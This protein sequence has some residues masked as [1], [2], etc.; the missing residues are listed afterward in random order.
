MRRVIGS[1]AAIGSVVLL[2]WLMAERPVYSHKPITTP[3]IFKKEIAQIFQRKCFQCHSENNLAMPL[4]TYELARPWARAIREEILARHMPPWGAVHGFGEFANDLGLTQREMDIILSWADGGAPSGVVKAEENVPPVYVPAEPQWERGAPDEVVAV[5]AP[6]TVAPGSGDQIH[7]FELRTTLTTPRTIKALAFKPGDRRVVRYASVGDSAS[8]R[9][10]WSWT[11]WQT[12]FTLPA[13]VGYQLP[14]RAKLTLEIGYRA[15]EEPVVDKS[16]L[17]LYFAAGKPAREAVAETIVAGTADAAAGQPSNRVRAALSIS[18][19]REV[20]AIWPELT[21]RTK[22][23]ELASIAPDGVA[24][25]LLWVKD[26]R[27]DWPTPYVFREPVALAPGTR[28]VM[29]AYENNNGDKRV[30]GRPAMHLVT[31]PAGRVTDR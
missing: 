17:G 31:V 23:L 24:E 30:T 29:T 2:I 10:L 5:E 18:A 8:G 6:F 13:D 15:I 12:S 9:W 21:E 4:T 26:V 3:I 14:S 28:L 1:A 25:P 16:E 7:R 27:R 20:L 19:P 22:S 11:P